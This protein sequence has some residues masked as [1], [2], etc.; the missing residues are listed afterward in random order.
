MNIPFLPGVV[1][2]PPP[3]ASRGSLLSL[4]PAA[5]PLGG[6]NVVVRGTSG[7]V[8]PTALQ[9]ESQASLVSLAPALPRGNV[10]A[11]PQT[12]LPLP[13]LPIAPLSPIIGNPAQPRIVYEFGYPPRTVFVSKDQFP[14]W[15]S[16]F[17]VI[18]T[19]LVLLFIGF[20]I[21]TIIS[22]ARY[23][24]QQTPV[25]VP[26]NP[27]PL[28]DQD[29]GAALITT[30]GAV[31]YNNGESLVT[32]E[33]C[34]GPVKVDI[35]TTTVWNESTNTCVCIPPSYGG[36]CSFDAHDSRY[37]ALGQPSKFTDLTYTKQQVIT[38]NQQPVPLSF[39]HSSG[40]SKGIESC[41]KRCDQH[42]GC[43]GVE[44]I[45]V[46]NNPQ[47][48]SSCSLITS[49]PTLTPGA[50]ISYNPNQPIYVYLYRDGVR[51]II[52]NKVFIYNSPRPLRFWAQRSDALVG[53]ISQNQVTQ[54]NKIPERIVNDGRL[55]G[56][57]ST[58]LFTTSQFGSLVGGGN[59]SGDGTGTTSSTG[60]SVYVDHPTGTHT[61][62]AL[63]LPV[64]FTD[65]INSGASIY[66]MYAPAASSGSGG[67]GAPSNNILVYN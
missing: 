50:T 9:S 40:L 6:N 8:I 3:L 41:T 24:Q 19:I 38:P 10:V 34:L 39:Q 57:W 46:P 22:Y 67:V 12:I 65:A 32:K 28:V 16:W 59:T 25:P 54:V 23:D 55:T 4:S 63:A 13:S 48:L 14:W 29:I 52:D 44:Y 62:Y 35:G 66:V 11:P 18:I 17:Y 47:G 5:P 30:D 64:A 45:P 31:N 33:Q 36:T 15:K 2:V 27:I 43:L 53:P 61:D 56:V 26:I 51:P 58:T 7:I 60:G 20:V 49:N 21:W 1:T 37:Y 42:Q